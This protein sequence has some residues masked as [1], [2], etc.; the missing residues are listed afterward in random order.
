MHMEALSHLW[1]CVHRKVQD[2]P[3]NPQEQQLLDKNDGLATS[4]AP[5]GTAGTQGSSGG[6]IQRVAPLR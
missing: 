2:G 3:I 4:S 5:L 6:G 1:F